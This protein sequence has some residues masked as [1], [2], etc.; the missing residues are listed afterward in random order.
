MKKYTSRNKYSKELLEQIVR[1]NK[2]IKECLLELGRPL[3]GDNYKYFQRLVNKFGL[4]TSHFLTK[5]EQLKEKQI[6]KKYSLDEIFC[7]GTKFR[8]GDYLK[9]ILYKNNLKQPI[10]E[11]CGHDENWKTGKI[12]LIL[13]HINGINNDNRIEN[14][15][16]V[17]PNC[18]STLPTYK[19]RNIKTNKDKIKNKLNKQQT[20][21]YNIINKIISS[22]IDFTKKG[23]SIELGKI[24]GW[25]PQY[26]V[27]YVKINLPDIWGKC[28]KH[29]K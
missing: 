25:T 29:S 22:N 23:W 1:R 4:D 13:D 11:M 18:D 19:G 14:L 8:S 5:S 10:C 12:S 17:C 6:A 20:K 2:T 3:S 26:T 7:E 15:R 24:I 9:N 21:Q 28:F 27:K 16:I